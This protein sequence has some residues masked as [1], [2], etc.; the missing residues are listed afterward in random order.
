MNEKYRIILKQK[1]PLHIGYGKNIKT[2]NGT[3]PY[4][5]SFTFKGAVVASMNLEEERFSHEKS[6]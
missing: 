1:A 6:G 5:P 4:I 3:L 2:F